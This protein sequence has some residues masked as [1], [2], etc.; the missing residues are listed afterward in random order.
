MREILFRGKSCY[1][2]E[3]VEGY[4]SMEVGR[5]PYIQWLEYDD[6]YHEEV[7]EECAVILDTVGQYTGITDKNGKR[8]FEGDIVRLNEDYDYGSDNRFLRIPL[9]VEWDMEMAR[10]KAYKGVLPKGEVCVDTGLELYD[11]EYEVIGNIH[12]NPELLE[13]DQT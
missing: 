4:F 9:L 12:D 2:C 3:W 1:S 7:V 6:K 11:D 5:I 13:G 10:F 8:I